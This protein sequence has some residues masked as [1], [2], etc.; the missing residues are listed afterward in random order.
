MRVTR[1]KHSV[2]L[3]STRQ[4]LL[5]TGMQLACVSGLRALTVRGIAARAGVNPGSFVYH[6]GSRDAFL[7]LLT[8]AW[9]QPL[10]TQLQLHADVDCPPLVRLRTLVLQ[11]MDFMVCHRAFVAQLVLDVAAGEPAACRFIAAMSQRHPLLLLRAVEQAQHAGQIVAAH[12][13]QIL[14]FI[15]A[16]LGGPLLLA[17]IGAGVPSVSQDWLALCATFAHERG[18]IAERLDWAL[19]GLSLE[20]AVR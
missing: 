16:P 20:G 2:E 1:V 12:P 9:Y 5:D 13:L 17:E 3:T 15:M 18:P 4:V 14:L 10:F 6:F 8:E 11:L 19:K 7:T